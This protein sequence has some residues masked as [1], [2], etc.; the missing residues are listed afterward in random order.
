[1]SKIETWT[2][3]YLD[4]MRMQ[5]DPLA[6]DLIT[7]IY[8]TGQQDKLNEIIRPLSINMQTLKAGL[9][10]RLVPYLVESQKFPDWFDKEA[11]ERT[12]ATFMKYE[13]PIMASL[14]LA[15]LPLSYAAAKGAHVLVRTY[16]MTNNPQRRVM[17]TLQMVRDILTPGGLSPEGRGLRSMQKVRLLHAATRHLLVTQ[18]EWDSDYYGV[19][20]NLEDLAATNMLFSYLVIVTVPKLNV[21]F[22]EQEMLDYLHVWKFF[23]HMMGI[24]EELLADTMEEAEY[25]LTEVTRKRHFAQSQDGIDL[26]RSLA[27]MVAGY[28]PG[29]KVTHNIPFALI[30]YFCGEE[31]AN[32]LGVENTRWYDMLRPFQWFEPFFRENIQFQELALKAINLMFNGLYEAQA[33]VP[34]DRERAAYTLPIRLTQSWKLDDDAQS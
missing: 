7:Y 9:R 14:L 17:E 19:P 11:Y 2:N 24:R 5:A 34:I 6:D 33:I 13:L 29:S 32:L 15:A 22:S 28:M 1:M 27:E 8:K 25:F 12:C 18:S 16:R 3:D 21:S 26:T 10:E 23:G 30:R 20:I 4:A 31:D